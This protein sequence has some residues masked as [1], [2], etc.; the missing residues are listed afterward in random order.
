MWLQEVST[1][2]PL[3]VCKYTALQMYYINN[4]VKFFLKDYFRYNSVFSQNNFCHNY[5]LFSIK[6]YLVETIL[7]GK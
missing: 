6:N 1:S 4:R 7:D 3:E 5:N 2:D